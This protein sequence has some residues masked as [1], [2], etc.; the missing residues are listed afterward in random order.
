MYEGA[1]PLGLVGYDAS[2]KQSN[3]IWNGIGIDRTPP[4]VTVQNRA[5]PD[6]ASFSGVNNTADASVATIYPG[7]HPTTPVHLDISDGGSG[8][9]WAGVSVDGVT[10]YV[11]GNPCTPNCSTMTVDTVMSVPTSVGT[12][13]LQIVTGDQLHYSYHSYNFETGY[14]I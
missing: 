13:T 4:Q 12:H 5:V 10:Q 6:G 7:S 1:F 2:G 11:A 14:M 9:T 8:V 3:V